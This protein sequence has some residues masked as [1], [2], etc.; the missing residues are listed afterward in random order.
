M[1][2]VKL[3]LDVA[4][5]APHPGC[6]GRTKREETGRVKNVQ[7]GRLSVRHVVID[8]EARLEGSKGVCEEPSG[9]SP[10][11]KNGTVHI[12]IKRQMAACKHIPIFSPDVPIKK[13]PHTVDVLNTENSHLKCVDGLNKVRVE[14]A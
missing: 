6:V 9:V 13:C 3:I 1:Q 7:E 2:R 4:A 14:W 12:V 11:F 8:S 5:G 10:R